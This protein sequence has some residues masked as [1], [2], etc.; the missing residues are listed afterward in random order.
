MSTKDLFKKGNKVLTKSQEEKIKKDLES[1][2]LAKDVVRANNKFHSHI[3]FSKPEN[4]SFY[5][6]AQKYYEDSFN[7][8]YQTYPYDGSLSEKEKW[9][10]DSSEL[11]LWIL[12]NVYPKSTGY[13]RLGTN[14]SIFVKGG[15]NKEPSVIEGEKEEL[16]KQFPVKQGNS[17]IWDPSI[18]R[19]SNLHLDLSLGF[20]V[21]L[22]M[23]FDNPEEP[24]FTPFVIGN[25]GTTGRDGDGSTGA[26]RLSIE[27][28]GSGSGVLTISLYDDDF[29][30][31]TFNA[32]GLNNF[33]ESTWN[34][35]SFSFINSGDKIKTEIYKNGILVADYL[36]GTSLGEISQEELYL[37]INGTMSSISATRS[38]TTDGMYVD[39]FRFW[40]RRRTAEEIGRY[41][42]TH[43]DGG[44]NTDDNKYS[45]ENRKVDIGVYYKFNEG[46]TGYDDIDSTVLDYSGRISNGE[47][48]NY[49]SSVRSTDSAFNES[50]FFEVSEERDPII[51]SS[52]PAFISIKEFYMQEGLT[53]DY[54]N[55]SSIYH[56]MPAWII[57]EDEK[58]GNNTKELSQVISSYFDSAQVKIKELVNLKD[59]DYHTLEERTN[60]PY[61]LIRRTLE[62]AGMT[63]PDLFTE[64]SAFE[65][66]LSRNEKE[67]FEEKLQDVKNTIYQ[68]IYNNLSYIYKSKGTEK[69]FRNLIRCFG[70]DDELIKINLYS[71]GADYTLED[72]RRTTAIKKKF[73]DFNSA[74]R[75][76]GVIYT[77]EDPNNSDS[78]SYIRGV[79]SDK[80][81]NI[82]FTFQTEI[83]FPKRVPVDHVSYQPPTNSVE[84]IA[85]LGK[86]DNGYTTD[87]LFELKAVK[88]DTNSQSENIK[89]VLTFEGNNFIETEFVSSVY[90]NSKWNLAVRLVP[91]K[92]L[93]SR[94]L[95][96]STTDYR[97]ELYC[98]RMLAD[99]IEEEILETKDLSE[100][101][102]RSLLQKDKFVSIGAKST[103]G[104]P[105][106]APVNNS[107]R[108]KISSILF[109]YD[110]LTN[111]EIQAH[112]S[113]ASNFGRLYPSEEAYLLDD[114]FNTV[115]PPT[116]QPGIQVPRRDTLAMH[117][118]FSEVTTTDANGKFI[119]EDISG[120]VESGRYGWF[121]ELVG[122]Q[123]TG[124]GIHFDANDDQI[125]NREFIYSAKH[126]TPEVINS[127]D[128][129]EIRNQDDLT[130]TKQAQVS[131]HFFAA[132]KSMYQII[133]DDMINL[134]AT[135]VEFN[136]LIGQPVNRYRMQYKALEKFRARYFEKVKNVPS[137]EKYIELYKWIDSSIGLM[138]QD[139]IPVSSNFSAD[140]RNMV[141]SH[142]LERNKYW[143]KFPTMEMAGEP[144]LGIIKSINELTYNWKDGHAP[145]LGTKNIYYGAEFAG[146]NNSYIEFPDTDEL[147]FTNGAGSD[148]SFSV[149]LWVKPASYNTGILFRKGESLPSSSVEYS[150][151]FS[152]NTQSG[153][154]ELS[155]V[156]SNSTNPAQSIMGNI[157]STSILPT[158]KY[159]HLFITYNGSESSNGVKVYV[160]RVLQT[161]L[162]TADYSYLGMQNS[163]SDLIVGKGYE[164]IIRDFIIYDTV[165]PSADIQNYPFVFTG[166]DEQ[167]FG[168]DVLFHWSFDTDAN[169]NAG[170]TVND[171]T[172][173]NVVFPPPLVKN[174][175]DPDDSFLWFDKRVQGID[176]LVTT[177]DPN[178]DANRE[179]LRRVS[180]RV[181]QGNTVIVDERDGNKDVEEDKPILRQS[182]PSQGVP[183]SAYSGQAYVTRALSKPYKLNLDISDTLHGGV[184][185][186]PTTKDP[187][188]Y[189][190]AMT[191]IIPGDVTVGIDVDLANNP[192]T[193]EQ[194]KELYTVKR[195]ITVTIEEKDLA[196]IVSSLILGAS[197]H[198]ADNVTESIVVPHHVDFDMVNSAGGDLPFSVAFW[199]KKSG[200]G[201]GY[202][203]SKGPV[204][205]A[206]GSKWEYQLFIL[207]GQ[208]GHL[209]FKLTESQNPNTHSVVY[210]TV[211]GTI[212][213]GEWTHIVL[214]YD[215]VPYS[216]SPSEPIQAPGRVKIYKNGVFHQLASYS[217]TGTGNYQQMGPLDL[218]SSFQIGFRDTASTTFHL[219][220]KLSNLILF[221]DFTLTE[222]QALE[223]KE[224]GINEYS[225]LSTISSAVAHFPLA[226][227]AKSTI[228]GHEGVTTGIEFTTIDVPPISTLPVSSD[229]SFKP[230]SIGFDG[231]IFYPYYGEDFRDASAFITGH[232]NDSYGD[233]AEIPVQSPFTETWV[234]GNQHRH[235][236]WLTGYENKGSANFVTD[237]NK[238]I[239]V[240]ADTHNDFS[241]TNGA[242]QDYSFA[243][244]FWAKPNLSATQYVISKS[245]SFNK[246]WHVHLDQDTVRLNL[247]GMNGNGTNSMMSQTAL[248]RI[249]L[250]SDEWH[251]VV[252]NFQAALKPNYTDSFATFYINNVYA[253]F[254]NL[255]GSY[256]GMGIRSQ[257]PVVIGNIQD[258][259][260]GI[261][262]GPNGMNGELRDI[263]IFNFKNQSNGLSASDVEQLYNDNIANHPRSSKIV[264]WWKLYQDGSGYLGRDGV[265]D[266][267]ITFNTFPPVA[268]P[269]TRPE[270]YVEQ[271][272]TLKHPH[273]ANPF[274]AAARYTRDE[275]AKRPINI[276]NIKTGESH[277]LGNYA[278]DYEVVQTSSR[279]KNNR[280]FVRNEGSVT[281]TYTESPF[282]SGSFEF[283][284]PD[285]GR[286]EHV[287]VERFSAPGDP[288]TLSRGY[289]DRISEEFSVHNSI[290]Y[291]NFDDRE[292]HRNNLVAHSDLF[293]GSQG[294]VDDTNG[295]ANIHKINRNTIHIPTGKNYDNAFVSHQIPRS[296]FQYNVEMLSE[297]R[298]FYDFENFSDWNND[299]TR[300]GGSAIF[301]ASAGG[302]AFRWNSTHSA[303]LVDP[304]AGSGFT[305]K[306][307]QYKKPIHSKV[308]ISFTFED[309]SA[310]VVGENLYLQ[311]SFAP[312][313]SW[314]TLE[315]FE[316]GF[317][318]T[319]TNGFY[320]ATVDLGQSINNPIYFRWVVRRAAPNGNGLWSVDSITIS[321]TSLMQYPEH[322][323]IV[324]G[325]NSYAD[326][327]G[328]GFRFIR[329]ADKKAVVEQRKNNIYSQLNRDTTTRDRR[330]SSFT[331]PAV[332]W[333][334]PNTHFVLNERYDELVRSGREAPT[335]GESN[336]RLRAR[337]QNIRK[338]SNP[339][340]YSYSNGL[341]MFSNKALT[342]AIN[343]RVKSNSQFIDALMAL[344]RRADLL[345][346]KSIAREIIFPKH[347]N[348]GLKKSRNRSYFDS[349]KFFWKDQMLDR[350]SCSE[351]TKL[352]YTLTPEF[353]DL[354]RQHYSVDVMDNYFLDVKTTNS[355]AS[356]N[357]TSSAVEVPDAPNLSFTSGGMSISTWIRFP[358]LGRPLDT[359]LYKVGEYFI[360]IN[361]AP[362][363]SMSHFLM[364]IYDGT[365]GPNL[366]INFHKDIE[367]DR[368]YH[369]VF[370]Y[371]GGLDETA[372]KCYI[373]GES[374]LRKGTG[375]IAD[376]MDDTDGVLRI[377]SG[378]E[379]ATSLFGLWHL[380]DVAIYSR[381]LENFEAIQLHSYVK[382]PDEIDGVVSY[383]KLNG[384]A[385]D[386]VGNNHG[387]MI[388]GSFPS[389]TDSYKVLGD[390]S[391]VGED[392][393]RAFITKSD[394]E[395]IH[396][397]S[398]TAFRVLD[399]KCGEEEATLEIVPVYFS[400]GIEIEKRSPVPTAQLYH[401]PHNE[402]YRES[403][404][405]INRKSIISKQKSTYNDYDS[406]SEDIRAAAQNY[407]LVSEFRISE[408]MDRYIL[409]NGGNFKAKNYD[410]L[411]LDGASYDGEFHTLS[412]GTAVKE[413]SSFYSIREED[414]SLVVDNYPT[415][416]SQTDVLVNNNAQGYHGFNL[417]YSPDGSDFDISNSV[418]SEISINGSQSENQI[419]INPHQS[420]INAAGMFNLYSSDDDYLKVSLNDF[421]FPGS[422]VIGTKSIIVSLDY[423]DEQMFRLNPSPTTFSIWAQPE[424]LRDDG[425]DYYS[426]AIYQIQTTENI[427][428]IS[429]VHSIC[430]FSKFEFPAADS[431]YRE[432][433]LTLVISGGDFMVADTDFPDGPINDHSPV[434]TF[435]KSDGSAAHLENSKMNSV[436]FQLIPPRN[437]NEEHSY[438][439]K[440]W[441]NGEELYGVHIRE[442]DSSVYT[443]RVD[444]SQSINGYSPTP[445]GKWKMSGDKPWRTDYTPSFNDTTR[446]LRNISYLDEVILGKASSS[447]SSGS[448]YKF[449]G[450]LDEFCV[451]RGVLPSSSVRAIYNN[452]IPNNLNELV[453]NNQIVGNCTYEDTVTTKIVTGFNPGP[454]PFGIGQ[455]TFSSLMVS[456]DFDNGQFDVELDAST[457]KSIVV[458][459]GSAPSITKMTFGE[460]YSPSVQSE[461]DANLAVW[462]RIGVPSYDKVTRQEGWDEDFFDTYVHTDNINFIEKSDAKHDRLG[463]ETREGIRLKVNA[464][465]KMLPYDGF[466]PQD[467]TV[468]LANLF[469]EKISPDIVYNEKVSRNQAIQAALQHFFAPGILYNSIKS[470][471]AC[472]WAS[473]TNV[474]GTEPS[475]LNQPIT[476]FKYDST[477]SPPGYTRE[478]KYA[479]APPSWYVRNAEFDAVDGEGLQD[480]TNPH[481]Y[482]SV[483][484]GEILGATELSIKHLSDDEA[485]NTFSTTHLYGQVTSRPD[486]DGDVLS[487][488]DGFLINR[489]PDKRLPFEAILDPIHY[490]HD[491]RDG[492]GIDWD[493]K[494]LPGFPTTES[495]VVSKPNQHFS[496]MPS[497][498]KDYAK[499]NYVQV[500]TNLASPTKLEANGSLYNFP[501]F[502]IKA[503][504]T[505][506]DVR[507]ELAVNNFIAESTKFFIKDE[508]LLS[509]SAEIPQGEGYMLSDE[510]T[511]YMDVVI[512]KDSSF[513]PVNSPGSLGARYFGPPV[514]Y[515]DPQHIFSRREEKVNDLCYLPYAPPY[516]FG[517]QTA[518][519]SFSP[520]SS[521]LHS[522]DDIL[523]NLEIDEFIAEETQQYYETT[524]STLGV[525]FNIFGNLQSPGSSRDKLIDFYNSPSFKARMPLESSIEL[526][527]KTKLL[528][529]SYDPNGN[530]FGLETPDSDELNT[531]VIYSKF[532]C[533]LFNFSGI[534]NSSPEGTLSSM[535]ITQG[536]SD[537]STMNNFIYSA[538]YLDPNNSVGFTTDAR[539]G[540]GL[541][542]GWGNQVDGKGVTISIRES[543][544]KDVVRRDPTIGSLLKVCGFTPS[545]KQVGRVADSKEISEAV[546][547]IPFVDNPIK[548]QSRNSN[549]DEA[550][551]TVRIDDRNFIRVP[552]AV[553]AEQ[554][555]RMDVNEPIYLRDNELEVRETSITKM[556]K[557]M[558]KYNIP[559]R[560]DFET[561]SDIEPFAMYFFEFNHTLDREDLSNIWQGLQPK[562]SRQAVL[563]SVEISH[564]INS[565]ELFGDLQELPKG[566]RWMV[567]KVKKKAEKSYYRLTEDSRDD[568]RFKFNFDVGIK[569]PEY[570]YNYPY[571][572]FTMLEMIQVEVNSEKD[573]DPLEQ[574]RKIAGEEE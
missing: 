223:I 431:S 323:D 273:E 552:P 93:S 87:E 22:W 446:K 362:S 379:T 451:I 345:F 94:V 122:H 405:W 86:Y 265:V 453:Q 25:S 513:L 356:F 276:R 252:V 470:G 415:S 292:T 49:D 30:G 488:V 270:L 272:E 410:F 340:T 187:N 501:S 98:V 118:D 297:E 257:I 78:T 329:N 435:F 309:E 201:G 374:I 79:P 444:N 515:T 36:N 234:G 424:A 97:V 63:V 275:V 536:F 547:M 544:P 92:S 456:G 232:H 34:H 13:V 562:P 496:M 241:F 543:F 381:V 72:S 498:Y 71:D 250:D 302:Q 54:T 370:T 28:L 548:R 396:E 27:S 258:T 106:A 42:H 466:Y 209:R 4:F 376:S 240:P 457:G 1:P 463:V 210:N 221:K 137:L 278:K 447:K 182:P 23:K 312:D 546:V 311:Y 81:A 43:I 135:L 416:E 531:W 76:Q 141:E 169:S 508:R 529:Q 269:F 382:S 338:N 128:L 203:F 305:H 138:I 350:I 360:N 29:S 189:V 478:I 551:D 572:Y 191:R 351:N 24:S 567:F 325:S 211:S 202:I 195:S 375:T 268:N 368:W 505:S 386:S 507:Y 274:R 148:D 568:K 363:G 52:H 47:I 116:G 334:K 331:E 3:D 143:T 316:Q 472:D 162:Q 538:S 277:L 455:P 561:F 206:G 524:L 401:N 146:N 231:D 38:K 217:M 180:T 6:S 392:R 441:L 161:P 134:F 373:D 537:S 418:N 393:M 264:G 68:N 558:R 449:R 233:D 541:W 320:Q 535:G 365:G 332:S 57:E 394:I 467:R 476:V 481:V 172:S 388:S 408:H 255:A 65:E 246:E 186:S 192:V 251:H 188:A 357:G 267:G 387:Q 284:L 126:R 407:S 510:K 213:D 440:M 353:Q 491:G 33:F 550:F 569:E 468:Q 533:P 159:S 495:Y 120:G 384:N 32:T 173:Y 530:I 95:G 158:N 178:V 216:S 64:A 352:G 229:E 443:G 497:Y 89:F 479:H 571:D 335:D 133:S 12:D 8:I 500:T 377:G 364:G 557:G 458:K 153:E 563:D 426:K 306:Y 263:V 222:A 20:T 44:T 517:E 433:G 157:Y 420:G 359:M 132:E 163:T 90:E 249:D 344:F 155:V 566:I 183:G 324:K 152:T 354:F 46:I 107:T 88:E 228:G 361:P 518:R 51:Y 471:I 125:V 526:R 248:K 315:V 348:V 282:I 75:D 301:I 271:E 184:N 442:F 166:D 512:S 574:Y 45:L 322:A 219:V 287:I 298:K 300:S 124:S 355:Y 167:I 283:E 243:I 432:L 532:E 144:P 398:P 321:P 343:R 516:F 91:K 115:Y 482:Y 37:N 395:P 462:H 171:G 7:R 307:L 16:S 160:D 485:T 108:L 429:G 519:I 193:Y 310:N 112:G 236:P 366:N 317:G 554:R 489:E 235:V 239:V 214:T 207:S 525:N 215:A 164:G 528:K 174:L 475:Y 208:G 131:T 314:T 256:N 504:S 539:T 380:K 5:G 299:F 18:Q 464:V 151:G 333:N 96:G 102:A 220:G 281:S 358:D 218:Q 465:K 9:F 417:I 244:S 452:G 147:S 477:T 111:E 104:N 73:I 39:E 564:E 430:L 573:I 286:T 414:D 261:A 294:Y 237:D 542:A 280:W 556:I 245:L 253:G 448:E 341:E 371:D 181:S 487:T 19:T 391:Y 509:F 521:G 520:T 483:N 35:Y 196:A 559:P 419:Q 389:E 436:I 142:V 99:L 295:L 565:F 69:A 60:K 425:A 337:R 339:I 145:G 486:T 59:V 247:F 434:Y 527:G 400:D 66:I 399:G 156:F 61:T 200:S 58:R 428:G 109:W 129:V 110:Y 411:T 330:V 327:Q 85:Y 77:K 288:L 326:Y 404:G 523:D 197:I 53:Y 230:T 205:N 285:R 150:V 199:I 130:F 176:P 260:P 31:V 262:A 460:N 570:G 555:R 114:D 123:V 494:P 406:Y 289:L 40:K 303:M 177:G 346:S 469:V 454:G 506:N 336:V 105:E 119:V 413:T 14:Q 540:S 242:G 378:S 225:T 480:S 421:N 224:A 279:A 140:L 328:A 549:S 296:D 372:I 461:I 41:W 385:N 204:S 503:K 484:K 149:S 11:D 412:S 493:G 318:Y 534:A 266:D 62:S 313:T 165:I 437:N 154:Q 2:E 514:A 100:T 259:G 499:D 367:Q 291:R 304:P 168:T 15:P 139:L 185:Y 74:Q 136:N 522:L 113:D 319:H 190:R 473:Y 390:L 227:D 254:D 402:S 290:N 409:E 103:T 55:N 347:K 422:N 308:T 492:D 10:Y 545:T 238:E 459:S 70:V 83:I 293:E 383:W 198:N 170:F 403:Q 26:E 349:Y 117:W 369:L 121:T 80:D 450:L 502:E 21:E 82:S 84:H 212:D 101:E 438:L 560:Y 226:S 423:T 17:N 427:P 67:K 439:V 127:E 511:Y 194:W 490:L 474:C 48:I 56:T 553:H 445:I 342:R 397:S 179:I 50:E 175:N